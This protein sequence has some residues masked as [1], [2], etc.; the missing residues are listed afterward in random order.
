MNSNLSR[1]DSQASIMDNFLPELILAIAEFL[2]RSSAACLTLCNKRFSE[3]L[4]KKYFELE[5][6]RMLG[7]YY[8]ELERAVFLSL[9]SRDLPDHF[10]CYKC[11]ILHRND[12]VSGPLA[13]LQR[14]SCVQNGQCYTQWDNSDYKLKFAHVQAW[15]RYLRYQYRY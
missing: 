12:L 1:I 8:S 9:L 15:F 2:P 5:E 7:G 6:S 3:I 10:H 4:G 11:W 14:L 13:P